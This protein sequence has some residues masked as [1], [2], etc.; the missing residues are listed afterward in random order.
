MIRGMEDF[1]SKKLNLISTTACRTFRQKEVRILNWAYTHIKHL[2]ILTW[3]DI[4][5]FIKWVVSLQVVGVCQIFLDERKLPATEDQ[6][7][8]KTFDLQLRCQHNV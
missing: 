5:E 2:H 4:L 6:A 7:I 8:G 3:V 1:S